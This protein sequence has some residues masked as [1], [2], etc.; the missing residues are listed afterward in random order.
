MIKSYGGAPPLEQEALN[1]LKKEIYSNTCDI[2]K[3]DSK[4]SY[5]QTSLW[6]SEKMHENKPTVPDMHDHQEQK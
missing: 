3:S 2:G 5:K 6:K 4:H 1:C